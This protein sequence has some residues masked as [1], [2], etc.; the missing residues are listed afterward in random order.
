MRAAR[1]CAV[2]GAQDWARRGCARG[3]C[4]GECAGEYYRDC[5]G[6]CAGAGECDANLR[7]RLFLNI[8]LPTRFALVSQ[9]ISSSVEIFDNIFFENSCI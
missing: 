5:A 9:R 4:D 8:S 6:G 3:E 2:V 7:L 1:D